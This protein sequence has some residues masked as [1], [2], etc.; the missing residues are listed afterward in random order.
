MPGLDITGH[1]SLSK[2]S[3]S[4][5]LK[6]RETKKERKSRDHNRDSG[7]DKTNCYPDIKTLKVGMKQLSVI[8]INVPAHHPPTLCRHHHFLHC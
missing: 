5:A 3:E 6:Q 2:R 7:R 4:L 1:K 8:R